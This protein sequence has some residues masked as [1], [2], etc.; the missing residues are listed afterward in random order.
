MQAEEQRRA[1][2]LT[3]GVA[4]L[5]NSPQ[6][7]ATDRAAG[8]QVGSSDCL[9]AMFYLSKRSIC[10]LASAVPHSSWILLPGN[11]SSSLERGRGVL[12]APSGFGGHWSLCLSMVGSPRDV[13]IAL[14]CGCHSAATVL[15]RWGPLL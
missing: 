14:P 10:R 12:P 8:S 5:V 1:G 2:G 3:A 9:L 7:A 15:R 13:G 4:P 6:A 11:G